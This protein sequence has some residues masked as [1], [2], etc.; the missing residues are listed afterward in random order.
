MKLRKK[1]PISE[2]FWEKVLK[3][4]GCWLWQAGLN[5]SGYGWIRVGVRPELAHRISW[6]LTFGEIP[7][8]LC[9]LH[10]CDVRRCVRPDHLFLGTVRDNNA[11]CVKKGRHRFGTSLGERHGQS[12][13]TEESVREIRASVAAGTTHGELSQKFGVTRSNIS[14]IARHQAWKG[15]L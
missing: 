10:E 13:L 8:G 15:V 1:R 11:D 7:S 3:S 6:R 12:K 14:R 9:V 2:R 4:E 5:S